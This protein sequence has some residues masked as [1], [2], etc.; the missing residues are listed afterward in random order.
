MLF[1]TILTCNTLKNLTQ[2]DLP[3][4]TVSGEL[5]VDASFNQSSFIEYLKKSGDCSVSLT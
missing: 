2:K 3:T 5:F 4:A 1:P